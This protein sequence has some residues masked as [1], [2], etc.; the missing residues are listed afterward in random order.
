MGSREGE[1]REGKWHGQVFYTY[2]EGPRK[3]KKDVERMLGRKTR[4]GKKKRFGR[5]H[6]ARDSYN[7]DHEG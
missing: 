2:A 6:N 5:G 1:K 3:G 4:G 7:A